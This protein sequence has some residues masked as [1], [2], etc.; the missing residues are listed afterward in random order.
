M[1]IN[2][3]VRYIFRYIHVRRY[4]KVFGLFWLLF[5]VNTLKMRAYERISEEK[6]GHCDCFASRG[7]GV[8]ASSAPPPFLATK[9]LTFYSLD[10]NLF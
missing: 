8:R 4:K 10:K 3:Y 6:I 9:S 1:L 5:D 2:P 7:S